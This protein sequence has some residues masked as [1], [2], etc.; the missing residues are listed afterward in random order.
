ML[1]LSSGK[2]F[3]LKWSFLPLVEF[4]LN[5]QNIAFSQKFSLKNVSIGQNG[6]LIEIKTGAR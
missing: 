2:I 5:G 6:V 1:H 4:G 3:V